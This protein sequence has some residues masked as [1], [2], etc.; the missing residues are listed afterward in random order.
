MKHRWKVIGFCIFSLSLAAI[1]VMAGGKGVIVVKPL[2]ADAQIT[3]DGQFTDWPLGDFQQVAEQPLFPDGQESDTTDARGDYIVY[4]PDRV[5]FFNS[6]RG[7]VSEDD[8]DLDFEVNT[9]FLYDQDFLYVLVVCVDDEIEDSLDPSDFG[10]APYLNDGIEFFFDA[11]NDSDDC[12]SDIAFPS[13]DAE[14]PNL[15]DFQIATGLNLYFPSV[16]PEGEGGL[17]AAQGIERSGDPDLFGTEKFASGTYIEA[18]DASPGPDIAAF[19]YEDLRAAGA[20]NAVIADNP[21]L[22]FYGYVMEI[23][24]PFGVVDGFTPDHSMG[25]DLFWRDVDPSSGGAIQ[26]IDWAQSTEV[27]CTNSYASLFYA[28]NWAT[29]EFGTTDVTD[30]EIH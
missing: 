2:A 20:P 27:A 19:L 28:P 4:D 6:A 17:G 26:F 7:A 22:E 13:F 8:P 14:E 25:F 30:W 18:M 12:A 11:K 10:S 9:Y 24:I 29:L 21:T 3:I 15:D 23:R 1:T 5:G 16:I